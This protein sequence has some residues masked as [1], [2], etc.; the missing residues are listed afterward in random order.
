MRLTYFFCELLTGLE[1]YYMIE[2]VHRQLYHIFV[3]LLQK[4][5]VMSGDP[6]K[7]LKDQKSLYNFSS[8]SSHANLLG[9]MS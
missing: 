3:S 5:A 1:S 9:I 6:L 4:L 7:R 2:K 8:V